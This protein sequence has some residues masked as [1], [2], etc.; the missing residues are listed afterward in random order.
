MIGARAVTAHADRADEI[1]EFYDGR[2][3]TVAPLVRALNFRA[4][5]L[6]GKGDPDAA[7][8]DARRALEV[9]RRLQ[10]DK[11]ASS[12]AGLSLLSIAR[13]EESRGAHDAAR[14][15]AKEALPHLTE[16]LGAEHPDARRAA[17]FS[18]N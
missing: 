1:V 6:L 11:P 2:S 13:I 10:G 17:Q 8:S 9:S 16:T 7:M 18:V 4:D 5:A 15:A 12:L 14:L 3:M